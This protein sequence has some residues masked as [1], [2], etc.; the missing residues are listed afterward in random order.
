MHVSLKNDIL[1]EY[2]NIFHCNKYERL[3]KLIKFLENYIPSDTETL[4]NS[5]SLKTF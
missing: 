1:G 3:D 2:G 4:D 5:N